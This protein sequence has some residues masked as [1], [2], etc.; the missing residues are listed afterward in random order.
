M[1]RLIRSEY[2]EALSANII[3]TPDNHNPEN[4]HLYIVPRNRF[5]SHAPGMVGMIGGIEVLG[6][7]VFSTEI[8]KQQL[9]TGRVDYKTVEQILAAVE[10]V[11]LENLMEE[12]SN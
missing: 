2:K 11:G 1:S 6:E 3:A 12:K 9:D 8:E 7:V 4:F 10:P 5:Y